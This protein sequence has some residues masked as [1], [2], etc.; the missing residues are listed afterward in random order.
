MKW[1]TRSDAKIDRLA[2]AWLILRFVDHEAEFL[3]AAPAEV[4]AVAARTGA[5]PFDT[6]GAELGDIDGRCAFE[7]ILLRYAL[8][9]DALVLMARLVHGADK[10]SEVPNVP[11]QAEGL[12]AIILGY[13]EAHD[14][15]PVRLAAILGMFDAV[16]AW[17]QRE[18]RQAQRLAAARARS[19]S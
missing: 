7:S 17:C 1:L 14:E 4:D 19:A 10:A 6:A 9:D 18:V 12:K 8:T 16:L 3:Y 5:T 15:D 13:C 11:A 2:S